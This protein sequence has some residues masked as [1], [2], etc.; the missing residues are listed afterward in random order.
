MYGLPRKSV[1]RFTTCCGRRGLDIWTRWNQNPI[2]PFK[3]SKINQIQGTT[4]NVFIMLSLIV[5]PL[6]PKCRTQSWELALGQWRQYCGIIL[7]ES[8]DEEF[9][10]QYPINEMRYRIHLSCSLNPCCML[11]SLSCNLRIVSLI[12]SWRVGNIVPSFMLY[13]SP[14]ANP[15]RLASCPRRHAY[16]IK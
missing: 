1:L 9:L 6:F 8:F 13:L 5:L 11:I 12:Q 16:L 15:Q 3:I 2:V 10:I 14:A 7:Y 4:K